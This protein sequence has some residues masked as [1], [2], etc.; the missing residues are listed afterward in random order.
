MDPPDPD[1]ESPGGAPADSGAA[2]VPEFSCLEA[3]AAPGPMVTVP[4]GEFLMGCNEELDSDC[5]PDELPA[6]SVSLDDFEIDVTEVTQTAYA[7]CIEDGACAAPTCEW[8]CT[9][10]DHPATCISRP[11]AKDYCAFAG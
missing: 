1:A 4:A 6:R 7:A 2:T 9:R 10:T 5:N 11:D 8:D 3:T